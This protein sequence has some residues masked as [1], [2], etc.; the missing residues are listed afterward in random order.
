[1]SKEATEIFHTVIGKLLFVA[2]NSRPD[3]SVAVSQLASFVSKPTVGHE[4]AMKR[5]LRYVKGTLDYGV[6]LGG[7]GTVPLLVGYADADWGGD[8]DTRKSRTGYLFFINSGC[9]TWN[10]KK[11][12]TV[13]LSTSEAEYMSL[14]AATAEVKWLVQLLSELGFEQNA[15]TINQDNQGCI[16]MARTRKTSKDETHRDETQIY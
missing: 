8:L 1:M 14:S 3:L 9:I 4:K 7:E 16:Q 6:I 11:Q 15:I 2:N 13:A 10:T 12:P 5:V